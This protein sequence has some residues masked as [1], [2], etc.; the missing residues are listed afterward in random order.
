L[1]RVG[2]AASK[3]LVLGSKLVELV[4]DGYSRRAGA[5]YARSLV[6]GAELSA[7]EE[8]LAREL[9]YLMASADGDLAA[10]ELMLLS[11]TLR[12][13]LETCVGEQASSAELGLPMLKLNETLEKFARSLAAE[14]LD[15]R[16]ASV[17]RRIKAPAGKSLAFRLAGG[18][19]FVDHVVEPGEVASLDQL[20]DAL[21]FSSR[22]Q[23]ELL[24]ELLAVLG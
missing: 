15:A 12:D 4:S 6:S 8:M 20:G 18:I 10:D 23:L 16:V 5:A 24:R 13:I 21:G 11:S 1:R 3:V 7:E 2:A 9:M 14:G 17:A 19:A 22:E